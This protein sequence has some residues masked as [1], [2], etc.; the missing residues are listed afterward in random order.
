MSPRFKNVVVGDTRHANTSCRRNAMFKKIL[1]VVDDQPAS[2]QAIRQGVEV[3]RGNCGEILFFHLLP[4]FNS[5]PVAMHEAV[6]PRSM[7]HERV[8]RAEASALLRKASSI[9]EAA[10][11]LSFR[12]MGS[13]GSNSEAKCIADVAEKRGS[14]LIVVAT[15]SRNALVRLM[16]RS[17]VPSLI[18]SAKVPVLVCQAQESS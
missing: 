12:S 14:Q 10:G 8:I 9:A 16:G 18:S 2:M 11:V 6:V 13:S 7:E 4:N 15:D 1:V 3:A 5:S 17:I